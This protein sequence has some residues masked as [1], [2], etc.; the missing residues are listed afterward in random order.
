VKFVLV[1]R[2]PRSERS[3]VGSSVGSIEPFLVMDPWPTT[4]EGWDEYLV[5]CSLVC[6]GALAFYKKCSL[7]DGPSGLRGDNLHGIMGAEGYFVDCLTAALERRFHG[8]KT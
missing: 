6:P 4:D 3:I 8:S 2:N 7:H 1:D 5:Y